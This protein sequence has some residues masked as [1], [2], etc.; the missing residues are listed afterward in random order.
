MPEMATAL[1]TWQAAVYAAEAAS[2]DRVGRRWW[3]TSGAQDFVDHLIDSDWFA[4]RWPWLLR[5]TI[6]RRGAGAVW[7][8]FHALDADGPGGRASEGVLLVAGAPLLEPVVLHELAHL[9]LPPGT[10]H[11]PAF[12]RTLLTLVRHEMGFFAYA[13][14]LSA[15]RA[16]GAFQTV[17]LS[18]M[19]T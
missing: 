13:E 15:L 3:W 17:D 8:T 2:I 11:G 19:A 18:S 6:E 5:C 14:L 4:A 7:S 1:G 16:T 9:L 10:D 12:A